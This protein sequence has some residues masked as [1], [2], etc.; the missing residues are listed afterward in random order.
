[1]CRDCAS[2][3]W[4]K[5]LTCAIT[6]CRQEDNHVS[7]ML[8]HKQDHEPWFIAMLWHRLWLQLST[9][10]FFQYVMAWHTWCSPHALIR[11]GTAFASINVLTMA[12]EPPWNMRHQK[13]LFLG[14]DRPTLQST[15]PTRSTECEVTYNSVVI[16]SNGLGLVLLKSYWK[17]CFKPT[18]LLNKQSSW[19]VMMDY[20][21]PIETSIYRLIYV[22]ISW[23]ISWSIYN[24][25]WVDR[26]SPTFNI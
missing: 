10:I 19:H 25:P 1:M 11:Q 26:V 14:H 17:K 22:S 23:S 16:E 21:G 7:P 18:L 5:A 13:K 9:V 6:H 3:P 24:H 15:Q 20:M 8:E 4:N 2:Q 12:F